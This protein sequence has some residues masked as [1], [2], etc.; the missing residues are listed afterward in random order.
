VSAAIRDLLAIRMK[1]TATLQM[2]MATALTG[3][4]Q[5]GLRRHFIDSATLLLDAAKELSK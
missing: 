2:Q 5:G 4:G 1:A 3:K